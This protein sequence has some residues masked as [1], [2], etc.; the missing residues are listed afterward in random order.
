MRFTNQ[1]VNYA[2]DWLI[3]LHGPIRDFVYKLACEFQYELPNLRNELAN[4]ATKFGTF[5]VKVS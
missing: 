5:V 4:F 2:F 1:F 3:L